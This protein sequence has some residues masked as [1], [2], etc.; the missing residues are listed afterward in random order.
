MNERKNSKLFYSF[1]GISGFLD[2]SHAI[3]F[4]NFIQALQEQN[5]KKCFSL[6]TKRLKC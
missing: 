1:L 2:V 3:Q 5:T 6:K 4:Q